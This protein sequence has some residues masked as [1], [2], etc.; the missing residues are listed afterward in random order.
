MQQHSVS[1]LI[2]PS[3]WL[4]RYYAL[5]AAVALAWVAAAF[6]VGPT[7]PRLAAFLLVVY[8]AWDA[9]ANYLD[10]RRSGGLSRNH[11]QALNVY[12][13]GATSIAVMIALTVGPTAVLGALG[14]WAILAGLLQL[15]T[16]IRRWRRT[17]AQWAMSLSGAQSALAG[18]IFLMQALKPDTPSA[19]TTLAG[20]AAFGALYFLVSSVW[21]AIQDMRRAPMPAG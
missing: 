6:A 11:T 16:A 7:S 14:V 9:L 12:V 17:G 5:R 8:P 10:A 2:E 20:Y 1:S 19:L 3:S 4:K 15:A 21:L 18:S 13:S